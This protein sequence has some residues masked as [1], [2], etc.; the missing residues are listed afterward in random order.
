M[1]RR[2]REERLESRLVH[3]RR[4]LH[5][6][7]RQQL[8]PRHPRFLLLFGARSARR[9]H[10]RATAA[11]AATPAAGR[12]PIEL[13][14]VLLEVRAEIVPF[15]GG[16]QLA[17][18]DDELGGLDQLERLAARLREGANLGNGG[19]ESGGGVRELRML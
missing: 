2:E 4:R 14:L 7:N 6:Q 9:D 10:G 15:G 8:V 13:R 5:E 19:V 16:D 12:L 3:R 18:S 17:E 11:D 1:L